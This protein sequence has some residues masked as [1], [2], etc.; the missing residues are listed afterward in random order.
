MITF[1][2]LNKD[3][4]KQL[5]EEGFI[6]DFLKVPFSKPHKSLNRFIPNGFRINK[7]KMPQIYKIYCDAIKT[8]NN[9]LV[10]YISNEIEHQFDESGI[11]S[12]IESIKADERD[13]SYKNIID[14][15]DLLWMAELHIPAHYAFLLNGI[16]VADDLCEASDKLY[17]A[18]Y[19]AVEKATEFAKQS[20]YDKGVEFL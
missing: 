19:G 8:G 1:G 7:L 3:N 5:I 13:I 16:E 4:L 15:S 11:S 6:A 2:L 17:I 14:V 12:Y 18:H 9:L 20:G 10:D